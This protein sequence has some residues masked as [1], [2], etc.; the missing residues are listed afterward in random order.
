[1]SKPLAQ[2]LLDIPF[3]RK[4]SK[5][6]YYEILK[7]EDAE[8]TQL[9]SPQKVVLGGI[10]KGMKYPDYESSGSPLFTK[11]LGSYEDELN[12]FFMETAVTQYSEIIDIGCAEGYYA[13]GLAMMHHE[14]KVYVYDIDDVALNRCR[15][16]ADVNGVANRIFFGSKCDKSTLVNFKFSGKGLILS[17]CEGYEKDLFDKE[18]ANALKNCDVIIELHDNAV[19]DIKQ[20]ITDAF[21]DTHSISFVTSR[22]K[23][24]KD[25]PV[26][27]TLPLPAMYKE[28]RFVEDRNT[29]MD[30]AVIRAKQ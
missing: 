19:P 20:R 26:L 13:V 7:Y 21:K 28:N 2:K 11:F 23:S 14:A 29:T 1:M 17:D 16:M 5:K 22:L 3:V 9:F 25:Y 15:A 4:I 10:F 27:A 6:I 30:W 8:L 18:T 12:P 24:Q